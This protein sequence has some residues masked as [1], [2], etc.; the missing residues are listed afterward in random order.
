MV[1]RYVLTNYPVGSLDEL[2]QAWFSKLPSLRVRILRA[3]IDA[4]PEP[5]SKPDL[6]E[7]A[8]QSPTS[9]GYTNNLG[10]LRGLGLE[11]VRINRGERLEVRSARALRVE[12]P[13]VAL[14]TAPA[15]AL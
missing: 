4:Y 15:P 8:G 14:P 5:V 13:A 3:L 12:L 2:H 6:A 1:K 11:A 9:S 10:A 7:E